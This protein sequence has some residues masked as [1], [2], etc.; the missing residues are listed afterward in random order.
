MIYL[1]DSNTFIQAKNFHYNPN[2]CSAY[3]DWILKMNQSNRLFSIS[4][5]YDELIKGND[6]LVNWS[7]TNSSLFIDCEDL[8]TQT[9]L[10]IISDY[11]EK[12]KAAMAVNAFPEF[13]KGADPWLI[14]KA[15][16]LNATVVTHETFN[17]Q[18]IKKFLSYFVDES[19]SSVCD[20]LAYLLLLNHK[21]PE[22]EKEIFRQTRNALGR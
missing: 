18:I 20:T 13:M 2:F 3:W 12:N 17:P 1:L 10:I 7:K 11:V 15:K 5:V 14:A 19:R 4:F 22:A 6:F 21:L 8:T 16:S 9:E